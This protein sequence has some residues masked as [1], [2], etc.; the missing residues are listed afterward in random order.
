[1][2]SHYSC[3]DIM[4]GSSSLRFGFSERE[5]KTFEERLNNKLTFYIKQLARQ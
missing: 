2:V 3:L 5:G 1:M 4:D